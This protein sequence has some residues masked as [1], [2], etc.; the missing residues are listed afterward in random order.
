MPTYRDIAVFLR[1]QFTSVPL[2]EYAPRPQE[3]SKDHGNVGKMPALF[4]DKSSTCSVYVPVRPGTQFW[5]GY[6]VHKPLPEDQVFF[7]KLFING[8]QIVNWSTGKEEGWKGKTA[9]GLFETADANGKKRVEKRVLFFAPPD[10]ALTGRGW[11]AVTD[12]LDEKSVIEIRV[13]R[14]HGRKRA[15]REMPVY[16]ETEHGKNPRGIN[17]KFGGR[18]GPEHP[19]QFFKVAL[20]DPIDEP[21]ARFR[22]YYRTLDQI[23]ELGL[24]LEGEHD[25]DAGSNLSIIEPSD[26]ENPTYAVEATGLGHSETPPPP[27]YIP[28]GAPHSNKEESDE[29]AARRHSGDTTPPQFYGKRLSVPPSVMLE[30]PKSRPLPP[31]PQKVDPSAQTDLHPHPA[32]PMDEWVVP[33]PSPVNNI[34]NAIPTPPLRKSSMAS[35]VMNAIAGTW[36]RHTT[37]SEPELSNEE[38][39]PTASHGAS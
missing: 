21:F 39:G 18:A 31:L 3:F 5:I 19:K 13:H 20:I 12:P 17:L 15:P 27:A 29:I 25:S 33:T 28:H 37:T 35:G 1:S 14:A 38:E 32:Y 16:A 4:D 8:A 6:T 7:F 9:F 22:Y 11:S 36:K 10:D 26:P 2:P 24:T 34:R 30:P 23:R